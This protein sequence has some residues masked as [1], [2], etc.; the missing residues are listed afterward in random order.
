MKKIVIFSAL[1]LTV[2]AASRAQADTLEMKDGRL[3]NGQYLGGTQRSIRFQIHSQVKVFPVQDVLALTFSSQ[4]ES[5]QGASGFPSQSSRAATPTPE[6]SAHTKIK[7]EL[8]LDPGAKISVRMLDSLSLDSSRKGDVFHGS[9]D[10]DVRV[11]GVTVLPRG[12]QVN[13]RVVRSEQRRNGATLA[14]TLGEVRL[15]DQVI[16]L[17]TSNYMVQEKSS[18]VIDLDLSTLRIVKRVRDMRIPYQSVVEF[19]TLQAITFYQ[20]Q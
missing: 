16:P 17:K 9:L 6:A 10:S 15:D 7:H 3:L 5:R 8:V 1:L 20:D 14:I 19:K 2:T 13:G 12:A 4:P 18:N 11:N